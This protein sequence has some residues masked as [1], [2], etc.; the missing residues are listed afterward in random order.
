MVSSSIDQDQDDSSSVIVTTTHSA[1]ITQ[2]Q[3]VTGVVL[4]V[5]AGIVIV[6]T[7][8]EI[9]R[10]HNRFDFDSDP[11]AMDKNELELE[12]NDGPSSVSSVE[13]SPPLKHRLRWFQ[14]TFILAQVGTLILLNYLLLVYLPASISLSVLAAFLI[15]CLTLHQV[16]VDECCR[17]SRYDRILVVLACFLLTAASLSLATFARLTQQEGTLYRGPARIIGYDTDKYSNKNN[18]STI[19]TD[20]RVSLSLSDALCKRRPFPLPQEALTPPPPSRFTR[21][22]KGKLWW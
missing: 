18:H 8:M 17:R 19:R 12:S 2:V 13:S 20:L 22:E 14:K 6:F 15:W 11:S 4:T 21:T 9:Q 16:I 1:E 5:L 10:H 3:L 7:L